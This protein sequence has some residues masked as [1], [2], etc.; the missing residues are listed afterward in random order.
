MRYFFVSYNYNN[1]I[2]SGFGNFTCTLNN[3]AYPSLSELIIGA[4]R[5][6]DTAYIL[7]G[8][9]VILNIIELSKKDYENFSR[10]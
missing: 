10:E 5:Q 7:N 6:L 1:P 9:P 4:E 3:D 2:G 8:Q